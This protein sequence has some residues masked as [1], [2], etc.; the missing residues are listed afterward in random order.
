LLPD[1]RTVKRTHIVAANSR[2]NIWVDHDD[3]ALRDTAVS[4]VLRVLNAVPVVAERAMWWP[5]DS[6]TW[7]EAHNSGGSTETG[8]RWGLAEGGFSGSQETFILIA[9]TSATFGDVRVTLVFQ[10]GTRLAKTFLIPGGSRFNVDTRAEF[11][12]AEGRRF[13]TIVESVGSAPLQLIVE[14]AMYRDAAG[15]KW[16]AGTNALATRL[17]DVPSEPDACRDEWDCPLTFGHCFPGGT[18][19]TCSLDERLNRKT[20]FMEG[21]CP[22]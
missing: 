21:P 11:P 14:R 7:D 10:D 17:S 16:A 6:A 3:E 5:V 20:C 19:F 15:Q 9:N 18:Y 2:Y 13:G 4:T 22:Q 8:A 1:A 12:T